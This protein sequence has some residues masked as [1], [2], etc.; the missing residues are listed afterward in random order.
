MPGR[1]GLGAPD[2]GN[3][4]ASA[5][6]AQ[7]A[8]A[9]SSRWHS[10]YAYVGRH[11]IDG[12][13]HLIAAAI[14]A[15][16]RGS[17]AEEWFFLR[18][19]DERGLH[20]RVRLKFRRGPEEAA[21]SSGVERVLASHLQ[22]MALAKHSTYRRMLPA[23]FPDLF[24]LYSTAGSRQFPFVESAEYQPE[25]ATY[26][27]NG[28]PIAERLFKVSSALAVRIVQGERAGDLDRKRILPALMAA[29]ASAFTRSAS[30]AFWDRYYA[31]WMNSDPGC[32]REWR[33]VFQA[34][35]RRLVAAG[36]RLLLPPGELS[37]LE[38]LLLQRW[39]CALDVAVA[40]LSR[41]EPGRSAERLA[42]AFIHL[43]SNRL[44]VSY[45]EESYLAQILQ[46][47]AQ[48]RTR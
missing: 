39:T 9:D 1:V 21:A 43:M 7:H 37:N 47:E 23:S 38:Q 36:Y 33:P 35:A 34:R 2:T 5:R 48:E 14:P 24:D 10:F 16:L 22:S 32:L 40:G 6:V 20:L 17:N 18:Y 29:V 15:V 41:V 8:V 12:L 27:P 46:D 31:Y 30:A 19:G 11:G 25:L 44:G 13:E 42:F 3:Q 28:M 26:G 4:S 45:A